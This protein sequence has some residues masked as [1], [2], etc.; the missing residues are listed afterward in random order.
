MSLLR[1]GVSQ[2]RISPPK[3]R[4]DVAKG[5]ALVQIALAFEN[6]ARGDITINAYEE[7]CRPFGAGAYI[8]AQN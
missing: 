1:D 7:R 2:I 6:T 4:H 5:A 3:G 8:N